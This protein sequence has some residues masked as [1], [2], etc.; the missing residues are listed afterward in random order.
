ME[1][2]TNCKKKIFKVLNLESIDSNMND[3]TNWTTLGF[4]IYYASFFLIYLQM[5]H[6]LFQ[7]AENRIRK[8]PIHVLFH[9]SIQYPSQSLFTKK[10][11]FTTHTQP[12]HTTE[13]HTACRHPH[14]T[15]PPRPHT[16]AHSAVA[17]PPRSL[18][19]AAPTLS[20]TQRTATSP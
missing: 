12:P 13:L 20:L 3:I 6:V 10:P 9:I 7:Y 11:N 17:P 14:C 19:R 18:G 2:K 15:P 4:A 8:N 1:K 16:I 5:P